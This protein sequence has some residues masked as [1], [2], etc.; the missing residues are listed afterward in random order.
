L[1]DHFGGKLHLGFE[2]VRNRLKQLREARGSRRLAPD[3][4]R[5]EHRDG[6]EDRRRSYDHERR[7]SRYDDR[8][9]DRR[10]DSRYR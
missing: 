2:A 1:A 5:P 10:S 7:R 9:D 6:Y 4:R 8:Y 3:E